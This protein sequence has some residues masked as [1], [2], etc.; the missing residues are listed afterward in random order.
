MHRTF[1]AV[2]A[3]LFLSC[4]SVAVADCAD[5]PIREEDAGSQRGIPHLAPPAAPT[6]TT[7][8]NVRDRFRRSTRTR[9]IHRRRRPLIPFA[10][11]GGGRL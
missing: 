8:A 9:V 5:H 7:V 11:G 1:R 10:K 6:A 3:V 2:L 4:G